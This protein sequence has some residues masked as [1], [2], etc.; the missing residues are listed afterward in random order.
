MTVQYSGF[1]KSLA[2]KGED[3]VATLTP[4]K[5][6]LLH[7][8]VGISGEAGELLDAVKKH[9]V[10]NKDVDRENVVEEL[11]DLKFYTQGIMNNLGI[12]HAEIEAS[13]RKKLE[14]RYASLTYTDE[15]AQLRADKA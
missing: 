3:I 12:T 7:H 11:G 4:Q 15:A 5:V 10:Y 1:V 13:N 8:A 9:V 14:A 2:K 6:D